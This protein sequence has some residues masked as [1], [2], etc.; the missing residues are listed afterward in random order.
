MVDQGEAGVSLDA[1]EERLG[2]WGFVDVE[3]GDAVGGRVD[4]V[5]C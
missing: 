3:D 4:D 5:V 1:G 2:A